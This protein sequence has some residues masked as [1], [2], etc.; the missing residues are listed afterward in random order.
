[1]YGAI[2]VIGE[3]VPPHVEME[4]DL[5]L[6]QYPCQHLVT[7]QTVSAIQLNRKHAMSANVQVGEIF[8]IR[9]YNVRN[10]I[11]L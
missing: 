8:L 3:I 11:I 7:E 4:K 2:S 5:V 6:E 10:I 1:M 9:I